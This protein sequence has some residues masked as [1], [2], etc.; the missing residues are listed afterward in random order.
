MQISIRYLRFGQSAV[1][2]YVQF[3]DAYA[4]DSIWSFFYASS[5]NH[6]KGKSILRECR[7][8]KN[9]DCNGLFFSKGDFLMCTVVVLSST[10][11]RKQDHLF[12]REI[13]LVFVVTG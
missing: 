7:Q 10:P 13:R 8:F 6:G 12:V 3:V 11:K 2:R 4:T 9:R 5:W 1:A